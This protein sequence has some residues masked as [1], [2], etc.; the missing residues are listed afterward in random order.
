MLKVCHVTL[1]TNTYR[2]SL[3]FSREQTNIWLAR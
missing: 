3:C 1:H 2:S